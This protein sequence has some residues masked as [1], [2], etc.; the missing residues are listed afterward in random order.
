VPVHFNDLLIVAAVAFTA[1]FLL[2][3]APA[4]RLPSVV[5][6]I[7]AGIVLGPSVLDW[8]H[9]DPAV[10]VIATVGLAFLLLLAGLEIDF[11]QFR[12]Q[13]LKLTSIGFAISF[14]IALAVGFGLDGAG[15]VQAP[16]LVAVILSATSLAIVLPVLRDSGLIASR[17]GQVVIAG[18]SIAD[19]ATVIMLSLFFSMKSGGIGVKL[20]LFG[21]FGLLCLVGAA[22][23]LAGS[24]VGRVSGAL[25][26]LQDT[27]AQIRV[28]GAFVL[29]LLFTLA[30]EKLGLEAILGA[31]IAGA[32][33]KI[34]DRDRMMT[35][36]HFHEKLSEVGFGIFVPVFFVTSGV[37]FDGHALFASSS[38]LARVP[39]FFVALLLIRGLPA[40]LYRPLIGLRLSIA[41][42][43]LQATTLS[44]PIVAS[45]IGVQLGLL[46]RAT[47]AGLIAAAL[48]SVLVYP[49]IA[50][51]LL[52]G[53]EQP[54]GLEPELSSRPNRA[55]SRETL[56]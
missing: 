36:T 13:L 37:R 11:D 16:F 30:A 15:L 50:L 53:E 29:L 47:G 52:A 46:S 39:V 20:L 18:T 23:I 19:V 33:L 27:S 28:R 21:G 55:A 10:S 1:P 7:V 2:G 5:L 12:G 48:V 45:Q 38:A 56:R 49:L 17:F 25:V 24:R 26:R 4:F 31:F 34:V 14:A 51:T 22:T 9:V 35:H 44:F 42:G 54:A 41:G 3:L 40:L 43:L 32:I 6:E 8:V